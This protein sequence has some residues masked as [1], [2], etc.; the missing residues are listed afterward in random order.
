[1]N[2]AGKIACKSIGVVGISLGLYDAYKVAGH[3]AKVGE[4]QAQAKYLTNAYFTS[5]TSDDVSFV[6]N[7]LREKTFDIR[8]KLSFPAA[9]GE[10]KGAVYGF[11]SGLGN[12]LPTITCSAIALAAKGTFAK[13]G[14]IGVGI[15]TAYDILRNGFGMNKQNPMN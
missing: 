15:C 5:R 3:Y 7:S 11:F 13:A 14:A 4:E 9:F 2:L 1:M 6:S 8:S 10:I 12:W